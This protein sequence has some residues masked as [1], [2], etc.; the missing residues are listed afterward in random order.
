MAI[1]RAAVRPDPQT[2]MVARE[3]HMQAFM[4]L[5]AMCWMA[6]GVGSVITDRARTD[7]PGEMVTTFAVVEW[8]DRT[9]AKPSAEAESHTLEE[10]TQPP[11]A[12]GNGAA[13]EG[14]NLLVQLSQQIGLPV[15]EIVAR[16]TGGGAP[17]VPATQPAQPAVEAPQ[18]DARES[19][20]HDG[21][22]E[23]VEAVLSSEDPEEDLSS[24]PEHLRG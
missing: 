3:Q 23:P 22:D 21:S 6:G 16:I 9:D 18:E 1:R 24:I 12:N 2:G 19:L 13:P 11:V 14:D 15:E 10:Q 20:R 5:E 8:K 4:D 7:V 17:E